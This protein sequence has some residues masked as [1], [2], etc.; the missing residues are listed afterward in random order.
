[1][2]KRFFLFFFIIF[3]FFNLS[4]TSKKDFSVKIEPY[5]GI[6]FGK[7]GEYVYNGM[8][9]R[10][11]SYLDWQMLPSYDF[12]A[13]FCF[14]Y[15]NFNLIFDANYKIP[16]KCGKMTDS[17]WKIY[18]IKTNYGIFDNYLSAKNYAFLFEINYDF[19]INNFLKIS[20]DAK[21]NFRH[22]SFYSSKGIG[23]YGNSE[24]YENVTSTLKLSHIECNQQ[25][26]FIF[27]GCDFKFSIKNLEISFSP[28][29]SPI[30][31]NYYIDYHSDENSNDI[32]EDYS[33]FSKQI[34]SFYAWDFNLNFLYKINKK[35]GV[36]I[37]F[38][39]LFFPKI[40]G[41]TGKTEGKKT[42]I[43]C[44]KENVDNWQILGQMTANDLY[45]FSAKIGCSFHF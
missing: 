7:L 12:G 11:L 16:T 30:M 42:E 25:S 43:L 27:L 9:T 17:D 23:W 8:A 20:P 14:S 38:D 35:F 10:V 26:F 13:N 24:S 28:F 22:Y 33:T 32:A 37:D 29:C 15:A 41:Q 40:A 45:D 5:A 36:V 6:I 2:K 1:M 34:S 3:S 4:A 21:L 18:N 31:M 39:F 19:K 44:F